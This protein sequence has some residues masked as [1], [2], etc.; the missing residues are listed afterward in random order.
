[1]STGQV[2]MTEVRWGNVGG[3][4]GLVQL[5]DV[6]VTPLLAEMDRS[7]DFR[8]MLE[9]RPLAGDPRRR[10]R[11]AP[12]SALDSA[13]EGFEMGVECRGLFKIDDHAEHRS[14]FLLDS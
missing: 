8:P 10:I 5:E 4:I 7:A 11:A 14:A 1:M 12:A 13:Q 2:L 9:A 3:T 6:S